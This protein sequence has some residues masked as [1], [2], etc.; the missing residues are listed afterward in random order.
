MR[1]TTIISFFLLILLTISCL[2]EPDAPGGS[3]KIVI[4]VTTIDTIK[5]TWTV[6]KSSV[7]NGGYNSITDHGF[8]WGTNPL[9]DLA[10]SSESLR[11]FQKDGQ[12]S[13][14]LTGLLPS[15]KYYIRAY[16]KDNNSVNYGNQSEFTTLVLTA[17]QINTTDVTNI[18]LTSVQCGGD[19]MSDGGG[20]ILTRGVCW[21]SAGSPTLTNCLNKTLDGTGSGSFVSQVAGLTRGTTYY[22]TAYATNEK[23]TGFGEVKT[24]TTLTIFYPTVFTSYATPIDSSA[25]CESNVSN[26]GGAPVTSRGVCW[27]VSMNPTINNMHTVDGVGTGWFNSNIT[28]LVPNTQYYVRAYATN[29]EGTAYGNELIFTTLP[30][31][32]YHIGQNFAGGIIFYIDST[33]LHGLI[34]APTDQSIAAQWGCSSKTIGGTSTGIG[35]GQAN[36]TRIVNGCSTAGIAARICDDLFMNGYGDW[37]LP[38]QDE[39]NQMYLQQNVIGGF[40]SGFYWSSSESTFNP[41]TSAYLQGF[42][43]GN[44]YGGR[45]YDTYHV[46]AIRAF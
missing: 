41:S 7:S 43:G 15:T 25:Q 23:D 10:G 24:F 19:V 33:G 3:N 20:T 17:P 44:Q 4:S 45:K 30:T 22:L 35:S 29:S 27:S 8:C 11:E 42:P 32:T 5:A 40:T 38:S 39:L 16:A 18:S 2:K 6:V 12:F 14:K 13:S 26:D 37:F 28:N 31:Q 1:Q 9:P 21:N 46:R 34:A 36:T